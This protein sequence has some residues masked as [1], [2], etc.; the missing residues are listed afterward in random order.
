MAFGRS[1][2]VTGANRGIGLEIVAQLVKHQNRPEFIFASCRSPDSATV[3]FHFAA[4]Q[5]RPMIED[6]HVCKQKDPLLKKKP[7]Q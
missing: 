4:Y 3:N 2:F 5:C 6:M 1:L 7:Y